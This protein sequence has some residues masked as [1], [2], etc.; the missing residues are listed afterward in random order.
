[1][2]QIAVERAIGKLVTDAAF[3]GRFFENP[4]AASLFAGLD[5]SRAELDAL[6]RISPRLLARF[7]AG[8]DDRIRRLV[9]EDSPVSAED[10]KG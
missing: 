8:L 3:F 5:L 4:A 7:S 10:R 6:V 1:M 9:V 2:T